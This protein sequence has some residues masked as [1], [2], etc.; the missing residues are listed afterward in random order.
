M[1]AAALSR[2]LRLGPPRVSGS[3]YRR[4][5]ALEPH[6][7]PE[8]ARRGGPLTPPPP[9][10]SL[11]GLLAPPRGHCSGL[12]TPLCS[13]PKLTAALFSSRGSPWPLG[14]SRPPPVVNTTLHRLGRALLP[15]GGSA[16]TNP[17]EVSDVKRP[18]PAPRGTLRARVA[19]TH[20]EP[21]R[22]R[23][24]P[25]HVGRVQ[26]A[27]HGSESGRLGGREELAPGTHLHSPGTEQPPWSRLHPCLHTAANGE[28]KDTLQQPHHTPRA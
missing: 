3:G 10:P 18:C 27:R 19:C 11:R 28:S 24:R 1:S 14:L 23:A 13:A 5:M 15:W 25:T 17:P 8:D 26:P 7:P 20:G 9:G 6:S 4:L 12:C 2:P 16:Q 21:H 22:S